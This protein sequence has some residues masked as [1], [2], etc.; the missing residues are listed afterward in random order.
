MVQ[1]AVVEELQGELVVQHPTH[2][3][4]SGGV[5]EVG[6]GETLCWDEPVHRTAGGHRG[7]TRPI[8]V[9]I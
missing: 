1:T 2:R 5:K 7:Q 9:S 6:H 8:W 4:T 3:S